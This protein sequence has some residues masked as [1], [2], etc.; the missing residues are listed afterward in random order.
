VYKNAAE[1]RV[2]YALLAVL[3]SVV[4]CGQTPAEVF[5]PVDAAVDVSEPVD[6]EVADVPVKPKDV[7]DTAEPD[8]EDDAGTDAVPDA[9]PDAK[10]DVKPDVPD[11]APV[12]AA[13]IAAPLDVWPDVA[14]VAD[15][16]DVDAEDAEVAVD[17]APDASPCVPICNGVSCDN[18]CGGNCDG[19]A[20]DDADLCTTGDTCVALACMGTAVDCE[21][22]NVCTNDAC[23]GATGACVHASDDTA[24]PA[25]GSCIAAPC[26]TVASSCAGGVVLCT[27]ATDTSTND[28]A[29]PGGKCASGVCLPAEC[30]PGSVICSS[31]ATQLCDDLGFWGQASACGAKFS[32]A[33]GVCQPWVCQPDAATCDGKART[34]CDGLGLA[35]TVTE[36]CAASSEVCDKGACVTPVCTPGAVDCGNASIRVCL[37]SALGYSETLCPEGYECTNAVCQEKICAPNALRCIGKTVV[38]CDAEGLDFSVSV[39]CAASGQTCQ[40]GSCVAPVCTSADN[41][42]NQKVANHCAS[43]GLSLTTATCDGWQS[44]QGGLCVDILCTP[45]K[46]VCQGETV[47]TCNAIGL[48]ANAT[49]DCTDS[50]QVCWQGA[51]MAVI[52]TPGAGQCAN[53]VPQTCNAKGTG[54]DNGVCATGQLC[55]GTGC[56]AA[57]C[58]AGELYCQGSIV[59]TCSPDGQGGSAVENCA[60]SGKAC[61]NGVCVVAAC[62]PGSK[63]CDSGHL[64]TCKSDATGWWMDTCDDYSTCTADGCDPVALAC[65]HPAIVCEDGNPCTNDYCQYGKCVGAWGDTQPC[66]DGDACTSL[67]FCFHGQC[68][69]HGAG[70]VVTIA[71]NGA[72]GH[73]DGLE[74][75]ATFNHPR[76][77][78]EL[79]DGSLLIADMDNH[80]IRRWIPGKSVTTFAGSGFA[81]FMEGDA[82]LAQFKS[83][84]GVAVGPDGTVYVADSGNFRIRQI[85]DG[86][87]STFSGTGVSGHVDGQANKA[88]YGAMAALHRDPNG[89]LMLAS[90]YYLI[91][92]GADGRATTF[93]GGGGYYQKVGPAVWQTSDV[94]PQDFAFAPD[95]SIFVSLYYNYP[96]IY[97]ISPQMEVSVAFDAGGCMVV[98]KQGTIWFQDEGNL[99]RGQTGGSYG[100]YAGVWS[101]GFADGVFTNALIGTGARM[102]LTNDGTWLLAD[103]VN[104]ALRKVKPVFSGCDDGNSCTVDSCQPDASCTHVALPDF[105]TCTDG[106]SCTQGDGCAAGICATGKLL[107]CNDGNECTDDGCDPWTG[108]CAHTQ[109]ISP[110][111]GGDACNLAMVC[112]TGTCGPGP[113]IESTRAG[114]PTS[115]SGFADGTGLA[116]LF[117]SAM[118]GLVKLVDGTLLVA[119]TANSALRRISN[120]G[121]V[122]TWG[123][124]G[125][126]LGTGPIGSVGTGSA[127]GVTT[128][129]RGNVYF[130][131]GNAIGRIVQ[132]QAAI[133]CGTGSVGVLDGTCATAKFS[134]PSQL[135]FAADGTL[136]LADTGNHVLRAISPAGIVST[137]AGT[138]VKG[139]GD[140]PALSA[141][142]DAPQ[143]IAIGPDGSVFFSDSGAQRIRKLKNGVVSTIAGGG[144]SVASPIQTSQLYLSKPKWL[145]VDFSGALYVADTTRLWKIV[146]GTATQVLGTVPTYSS[147]YIT[148]GPTTTAQQVLV[149]GSVP[150]GDGSVDFVDDRTVRHLSAYVKTCDDGN[151]CTADSCDAT[152]GAC[153]HSNAADASNCSDGDA[154]TSADVCLSGAC[155]GTTLSCEDSEPCTVD[156]CNPYSAACEHIARP[157]FCDDGDVCTGAEACLNGVCTSKVAMISH[158][159][160]SSHGESGFA[161]G[162]AWLSRFQNVSKACGDA[163]GNVYVLDSGNNRVRKVAP[164]GTTT[165]IAGDGTTNAV[166]PGPA[167]ASGIYY[168]YAI[169]CNSKGLLA[170]LTGSGLYDYVTDAKTGAA[171]LKFRANAGSDFVVT[172]YG[173]GTLDVGARIVGL[174]DGSVIATTV[175]SVYAN[176]YYTYTAYVYRVT[177]N[178]NVEAVSSSTVKTGWNGVT[179]GPGDAVHAIDSYGGIYR[180][181]PGSVQKVGT[182]SD[183]ESF[184]ASP[185]GS[186]YALVNGAFTRFDPGTGLTTVLAANGS[187]TDD[188][189]LGVANLNYWDVIAAPG[190]N[191]VVISNAGELRQIILPLNNCDD[192]NP[193]TLDTCDKVTGAC[194]HGPTDGSC[195][196]NNSCTTGDTCTG[197]T[198]AG[199]AITCASTQ[200]CVAGTCTTYFAGTQFLSIAEQAKLNGWAGE[201]SDHKWQ[202][203]F[204]GTLGAGSAET[205]FSACKGK[206]PSF[207]VIAT[208]DPVNPA[209]SHHFGAYQ[210]GKWLT[211]ASSG[212]A[213]HAQDDQAFLFSL[214]KNAKLGPLDPYFAYWG[215]YLASDMPG[216]K[217]GNSDIALSSGL[218]SGTMNLGDSYSTNSLACAGSMCKGWF[219]GTT[220]FTPTHV[221]VFYTP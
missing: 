214:D 163:A 12:D 98:D 175:D 150:N 71:G 137:A 101:G 58:K 221:E 44:C 112:S 159:A 181:Y 188:P 180:I 8:A 96:Q 87:V 68:Q 89:F 215:F 5:T 146:G 39:D 61:A 21:D 170:I 195:D 18:G 90:S 203:C 69:S 56:Q 138:G 24:V 211:S 86:I 176:F 48:A 191:R 53:G 85:K 118:G 152:T 123:I 164:D 200:T 31:N 63:S 174:D 213:V 198:C 173:P 55:I 205:L 171:T 216:P 134:A 160:G 135:A 25:S 206:G 4:G 129:R 102:L 167:L 153:S 36:D 166:S 41:S 34:V 17:V 64:L 59:A 19:Q 149:G 140:G 35:F 120:D 82:N 15:A 194:S 156:N 81:G 126:A 62:L 79:A 106:N 113:A 207:T 121:V 37:P 49:P 57:V 60:V 186:L 70:E 204:G 217:F 105:A 88:Q 208:D 28:A 83:P 23:D 27:A 131:S 11:V 30:T 77:M 109:S 187:K 92:I 165:T 122:T 26:Q 22:G 40:A 51:C 6:V 66:S 2:R 168:P 116:A 33:A 91:R 201:V 65:I 100:L 148:D 42:C 133:W 46:S 80:C 14:E 13:D 75:A 7:V 97:R 145:A 151:G 210:A 189:L 104:H 125:A 114:G 73:V 47:V 132:G 43:D 172:G 177:A 115:Y 199:V 158:L 139:Y 130:T 183:G 94:P 182:M 38:Q 143:G 76:G 93:M 128:D 190:A 127:L 162:D 193:C 107:N 218:T 10:P 154:C 74:S 9:K 136:Y 95:G 192:A 103:T 212:V 110:C 45:G 50:G 119:D 72:P 52:C 54:W 108:G 196:D 16:L 179:R 84:T 141:L 144:N 185:T 197:G 219:A 157:G 184:A 20:C 161:D 1:N 29:C 99:Y 117:G 124:K 3:V 78:A 142:I 220:A 67:D 209:I 169:A 155:T 202:K 147:G 111:T 32:C 178:G